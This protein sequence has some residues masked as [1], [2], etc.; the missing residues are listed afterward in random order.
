MRAFPL[1]WRTAAISV[2]LAVAST[3][4][5]HADKP[6]VSEL[7][8]RLVT[9]R[10]DLNDLYAQSAAASERLN[11]AAYELAQARKAVARHAA[12]VDKARRKLE[13]Q[14]SI[15][16]AMTVEQLQ[17]G[18]TASRLTTLFTSDGPQQLL[19]RASAYSS[20]NEALA[21]RVAAFK[22]RKVVLDSAARQ[23]QD[24]LDDQRRAIARQKS[25]KA[26]IDQA[27]SRAEQMA[28]T[29][30]QQ[31]HDLLVQLAEATGRSVDQVTNEQ[32]AIDDLIDESGPSTPPAP[33]PDPKP[34][35]TPTRTTP[36]PPPPVNPPPPSTSKVEKAIAFAKAQLGEPYKWGGAGPDSW[37][38]SGLT[39][40]A[41]QAAGISLPHY[42][43]AQY[44][45]TDP[46]P[47]KKIVRGDLLYWSDGGPGSIY[48][49]ALYL[50]DNMM[51]H[52]PRPGRSVEIVSLS[53]WIKP[54]LASRPG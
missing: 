18:S 9:L 40:R 37:D 54:D 24:A 4:S 31:R 15:V 5:A 38:C 10:Q 53:Y 3:T 45:N 21:S 29:V 25:A 7:Q 26:A 42:A 34:T 47:I 6:T 14:Q 43:G 46:V 20:T 12:E 52:A 48:H 28:S 44:A 1:A 41:W 13:V 22:A 39:M 8:I 35:P 33:G 19:D 32:D 16:A 51:I 30:D 17:S 27:I 50:G 49:E 2:V 23:A 11:G 36:P